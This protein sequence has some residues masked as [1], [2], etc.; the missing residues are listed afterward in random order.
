VFKKEEGW[1]FQDG[2]IFVIEIN[3]DKKSMRFGNRFWGWL[4]II[5]VGGILFAAIAVPNFVSRVRLGRRNACINNLRQI[6]GAKQTWAM[7]HKAAPDAVPTWQDI[8]PYLGRW[9]QGEIPKCPKGGVYTV[10]SV[11]VAPT[12]SI[13]GHRLE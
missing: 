4:A 1:F 8:Q 11:Q 5:F 6:D 7:E 13:K 3:S 12:C 10:G 9:P 2:G